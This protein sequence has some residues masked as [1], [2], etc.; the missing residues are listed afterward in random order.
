MIMASVDDWALKIQYLSIDPSS[1]GGGGVGEVG[2]RRWGGEV[3]GG[4]R[5]AS[6]KSPGETEV[7]DCPL[8]AP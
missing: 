5:E 7:P 8:T 3:G 6:T 2:G 1:L 4:G